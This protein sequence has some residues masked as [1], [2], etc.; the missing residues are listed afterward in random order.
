MRFFKPLR[1]GRLWIGGAVILL[2]SLFGPAFPALP[3]YVEVED[4]QGS[5]IVGPV[6]IKG[7]EGT[8][9][10]LTFLHA[11]AANRDASTGQATGVAH[12]ESL[13]VTFP[14]SQGSPRLVE[15]LVKNQTLKQ[16][17]FHCYRA[18]PSALEEEFIRLTV[19]DVQ[20][21][22]YRIDL[23]DR[24]DR[25]QVR[26]GLTETIGLAPGKLEE[27][28]LEPGAQ[29][30]SGG[31]KQLL[32]LPG[33]TD[34]SQALD[35]ADPVLLLEYLFRD[36]QIRCPYSGDMNGDGALDISDAVAMLLFLFGGG[37]PPPA[38][39]PDCGE[40]PPGSAIPC[41]QSACGAV[42]ASQ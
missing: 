12:L 40:A 37:R 30:G 9:E 22:S 39:Y 15:A 34:G 36:G 16:L 25:E 4:A 17:T 38:P 6:I 8:M 23:P 27:A 33:D 21:I 11:W 5:A 24:R 7:L 29:G 10:G 14:V 3:M 31:I 2:A 1:S 20:V 18:G 26:Y 42:P 32:Y 35:L 28:Y 13:E 19:H 41:H